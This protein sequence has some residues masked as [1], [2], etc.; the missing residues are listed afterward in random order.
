MDGKSL[1]GE[2]LSGL[3][4]EVK[5]LDKVPTLCVIQVGDDE[6]SNV[7]INQKRKMCNDIG[8][9]F[10][11]E[12]YDDSITED[13]LLKNIERFNSN[14][15]IDA[16]LVQMPLPSGINE[17]S[18]QNAVNKYKDVDGLNDSNIVDLI[19]GKSSLYPCTACGVISLLDKYGVILEGSN[20]VIV[21]R[22]SLVGMPLF[23][24]LENRNATVTLCHSKTRN[25]QSI[26]KNADI[27]ISA[28]GV[29]GL[30]KEDMVNNN[31]VV[32][33]VGITREN[34]KLYGDVDFDS[35]SKKASL[36]TPVPGGV[37]PMTIA[38]LAQNV[39]KAYKMQKRND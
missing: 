38:S 29:K 17:K 31:T 30:I 34:G 16:I 8:Y 9:N 24:M 6:A 1:K 35:V 28:T 25:L 39:L 19:S 27:I 20:V 26:T 7:Y 32:V 4:E 14:D 5:A 15:N 11:H 21:G 2:I 22:S 18:I 12:K 10:I 3:A 33:D 36:I 37:G 13:E 23:H